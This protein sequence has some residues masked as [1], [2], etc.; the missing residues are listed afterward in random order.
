MSTHKVLQWPATQVAIPFVLPQ[1]HF[2]EVGFLRATSVIGNASTTGISPE[3]SFSTVVLKQPGL[4]ALKELK[5]L[6]KAAVTLRV[7]SP[8]RQRAAEARKEGSLRFFISSGLI[9][10]EATCTALARGPTSM[11]KH[12]DAPPAFPLP[13]MPSATLDEPPS[14]RRP[15]GDELR[16]FWGRL[17]SAGFRAGAM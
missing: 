3:F 4:I 1:N 7:W 10:S 16:S 2:H 13:G 17:L 12:S 8:E 11:S 14:L 6:A 5:S 9:S 15:V